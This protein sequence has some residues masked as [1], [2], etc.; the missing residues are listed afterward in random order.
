MKTARV[1]DNVRK[2][3]KGAYLG[4]ALRPPTP[5]LNGQ[6]PLEVRARWTN[7]VRREVDVRPRS[8]W[9]ESEQDRGGK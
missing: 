5:T 6:A 3:T 7:A 1:E 2:S 4:T 8:V 9:S